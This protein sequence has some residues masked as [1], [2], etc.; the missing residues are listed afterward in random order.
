MDSP[1]Q[2][3]IASLSALIADRSRAAMLAALLGGVALPATDLARRAGVTRQTASAHLAKL[4][5]GG[6]IACQPQGRHRYY[7]LASSDV[8]DMLESLAVLAPRAPVRS[9][10]MSNAFLALAQARTC[11]DHIAG[12]LGVMLADRFLQDGLLAEVDTQW[13]LTSQGREALMVWGLDI[14]SLIENKRPF[15]RRCHD[16]SERRP[17]IAGALGAAITEKSLALNWLMHIA[18]SRALRLTRE[19]REGFAQVFGI[20]IDTEGPDNRLSASG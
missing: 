3:D 1:G 20:C 14:P 15:I 6:L 9:L 5:D 8:A 19:G 18:G 13:T 17:H 16:W 10:R 2:P 12:K 4:V 11:Y 7:A